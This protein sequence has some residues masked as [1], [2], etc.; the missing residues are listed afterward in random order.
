MNR[1][2]SKRTSPNFLHGLGFTLLGVPDLWM[3]VDCPR[4]L[5]EIYQQSGFTEH[6]WRQT[7]MRLDGK[8]R[9]F[10]TDLTAA[11]PDDKRLDEILPRL[12]ALARGESR[13][14]LILVSESVPARIIGV[15]LVDYADRIAEATGVTCRAVQTLTLN[16]DGYDAFEASLVEL[17]SALPSPAESTLDGS[18][19]IIGHFH[20]RDEEDHRADC[21]ELRTLV[22]GLGARVSSIWTS[23]ES[24]HEMA[25]ALCAS[26]LVA[27]PSGRRA[28]RRIAER[29]GATVLET[30]L[31]VGLEGTA[32]WL[33]QLGDA[34][35]REGAAEQLIERNLRKTTPI[36][37][38]LVA[39]ELVGRRVALVA[40]ASLAVALADY[41][42]ELGVEVIG[43]MLRQ[44]RA[45][46]EHPKLGFDPSVGS[47]DALLDEAS[48]NEPVDLVIGSTWEREAVAN[49][50]L[51]F[52]ELG[53]PSFHHRPLLPTPVLGFT[54]A[55]HFVERLTMALADARFQRGR[56]NANHER[57][58]NQ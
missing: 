7:L 30:R 52:V 54:G 25:R 34:L 17:A 44:R 14:G 18:V 58:G 51:P 29:S 20:D 6:A 26:L 4:C 46:S 28:A 39:R 21:T 38:P 19:A 49:R 15:D 56:P 3:V 12:E 8:D 13:P 5:A 27:L 10:S 41:L 57:G 2:F 11:N 22:E 24:T 9:L 50:G 47:L 23:G 42:R 35:D 16:R 1:D 31:P 37:A 40:E 32:N 43:P 53:F 55:L 36:L 33:R 48:A 45:S